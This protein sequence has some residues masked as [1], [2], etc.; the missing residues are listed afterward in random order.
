MKA[1][2]RCSAAMEQPSEKRESAER[3]DVGWLEPGE[4]AQIVA[5]QIYGGGAP[6]PVSCKRQRQNKA[7]DGAEQFNSMRAGEN[8]AG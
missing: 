8:G 3:D 7:A 6:Q 2:P 4:P 1:Q 5:A